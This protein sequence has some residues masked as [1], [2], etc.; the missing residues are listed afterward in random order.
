MT[1]RIGIN[2]Y[3]RIGRIVLRALF[4]AER[5]GELE[6]VAVNDLT[7][8]NT[9]A[10]LLKFDSILGRLPV[11]VGADGDH[12]VVGGAKVKAFAVKDGPA[13]LPWGDAGVDVVVE[14]TGQGPWPSRVGCQEGDHLRSRLRRGHH[15]RDGRQR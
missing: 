8:I 10:H 13:A 6:I 3:G 1:I 9:L 7:D 4:E 15:H 5:T 12:I 11:E 2:G 14:S